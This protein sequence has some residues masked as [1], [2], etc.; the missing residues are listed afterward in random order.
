[1]PPPIDDRSA[2]T[3][4]LRGDL[5]DL[6]CF[7]LYVGWRRAQQVYRPMLEGQNP[8]RVYLMHLLDDHQEL[9]VTGLA[10]ALDLDV[11]SASGLI[12]RMEKEGLVERHRKGRNRLE[13]RVRLSRRGKALYRKLAGAIEAFDRELVASMKPSDVRGLQRV[14]KRFEE[15]SDEA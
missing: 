12:S 1:M 5:A 3:K 4:D 8:Q 13:V 2:S 11:G 9:G 14:V 10:R 7:Q 6:P 15:L